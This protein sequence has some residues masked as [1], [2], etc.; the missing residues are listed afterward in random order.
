LLDR[1]GGYL[2]LD[3]TVIHKPYAKLLE[4]FGYIWD[5]SQHKSVYGIGLVL[6][7][8][9]NGRVRVPITYKVYK[10]GGTKRT[11]LALE[12]LSYARNRLKL[13]RIQGVMLD[14]WYSSKKI[15]K[16]IR[17]YG[18]HFY[19]QMRCNRLFKGVQ[20]KRYRFAIY[21]HETG[22][23]AGGIRVLMIKY[24]H[25]YFI[26]SNVS[27]NWR[28]ARNLYRFR[29]QSIEEVF[30][31]LKSQLCL[32]FLKDR[33]EHHFRSSYFSGVVSFCSVREV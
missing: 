7:L 11:E 8:W 18:W 1:I 25:K 27:L 10:K 29:R 21:W 12:L 15:L 19:S 17:D 33:K 4:W 14:S 9:T 28:E 31:I 24:D 13:R 2:I 16:R 26:T 6:L 5:H 23:L 20:V 3:D 30:K 22:T 32:C